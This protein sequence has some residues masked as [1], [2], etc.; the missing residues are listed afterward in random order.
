MEPTY[1]NRCLDGPK[2]TWTDIFHINSHNVLSKLLKLLMQFQSS[3]LTQYLTFALKKKEKK[4]KDNDR[5][6]KNN[7]WSPNASDN[8]YIM[9]CGCSHQIIIGTY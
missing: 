1:L 6:S 9:Y 2:S 5:D 7:S 4:K 3:T 8:P